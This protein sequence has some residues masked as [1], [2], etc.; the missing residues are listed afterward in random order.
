MRRFA[1]RAQQFDPVRRI[2]VLEYA[3]L[4]YFAAAT[5]I[6]TTLWKLLKRATTTA[7]A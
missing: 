7:M 2:G 1:G 4:I 5:T 6:S 3:E